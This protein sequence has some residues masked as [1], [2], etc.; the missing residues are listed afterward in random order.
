MGGI[1]SVVTISSF[2]AAI[3]MPILGVLIDRFGPKFFVA[4]TGFLLVVATLTLY[5]AS[6]YPLFLLAYLFF[7][8][9]FSLGQPARVSFIALSIPATAFGWYISVVSFSFSI[10]RTLGPT[11]GGYLAE[12]IGFKNTF[13][14]AT[15]LAF[16]GVIIFLVISKS[17]SA[18]DSSKKTKKI[19]SELKEVYMNLL[20]PRGMLGRA[21]FIIGVDRFGWALWFPLL[22]A[23]LYTHG[24]STQQAGYL[25]TLMAASQTISLPLVGK[26]VDKISV[27]KT[28]F[29]A[30]MV[31]VLG[32]LFLSNPQYLAGGLAAMVLVGI[33]IALW[34]PSYNKMLALITRRSETGRTYAGA[35][36]V[37]SVSSSISPVIGGFVYDT[38]S[39][40]LVFLWS[41]LMVL[42]AGGY[43]FN[44]LKGIEE[45]TVEKEV[46]EHF[47]HNGVPQ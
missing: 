1:G 19:T 39:P 23:H 36:T 20:K 7:F 11:V 14:Y 3:L 45:K 42:I 4:F 2:I 5:F 32:I 29:I 30:E 10:S 9:S 40:I 12:T 28:M 41:S 44:G 43:A 27:A 8:F 47:V 33:S 24:Y 37:R 22:S 17:V 38:I 13:L 25:L 16:L 35:N 46:S 34:I 18:R 31:G 15:L 6:S 26:I 21:Y